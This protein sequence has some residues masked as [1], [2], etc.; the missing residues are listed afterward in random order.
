MPN[1]ESQLIKRLMQNM[2]ERAKELRC[3][4]SVDEIIKGNG[5]NEIVFNRILEV[6]PAGWQHTTVC[7][8]RILYLGNFYS[9]P[10]FK[11]TPWMMTTE[12]VVDNRVCGRIDVAYL[13]SIHENAKS[14]FLPE[15]KQLLNAIADRIGNFLFNKRIQ[16]VLE[17]DTSDRDNT[18]GAIDTSEQPDTHWRW[19]RKMVEEMSKM[20]NGKGLGVKAVYLAG[21]VREQTAG[22]ASDI[23]LIIYFEGTDEQKNCLVAELDGWSKCLSFINME[24]TGYTTDK[25]IDIHF[26]NKQSIAQ[27]DSFALMI[28]PPVRADL[29][30]NFDTDA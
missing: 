22:P 5:S 2:N 4:Y 24:K 21:S 19:R 16:M 23:D 9:T 8:A 1:T 20:L 25:L 15:E 6:I 27:K 18:V 3:L 17:N 30:R 28:Q 7:E 26:I 11:E 10:D 14:N 29:I 12:I 13:Q